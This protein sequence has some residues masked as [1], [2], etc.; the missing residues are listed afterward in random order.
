MFK[1]PGGYTRHIGQVGTYGEHK[2]I[3]WKEG[4]GSLIA[5]SYD[6]LDG[7]CNVTL[8]TAT[9]VGHARN[10]PTN[11]DWDICEAHTRERGFITL[12]RESCDVRAWN[13]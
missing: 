7:T 8:Y 9:G 11:Q 5:T 13:D 6:N 10:V 3:T 2:F 1:Q 12:I 4:N